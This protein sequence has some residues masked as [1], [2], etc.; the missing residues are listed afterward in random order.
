MAEVSVLLDVLIAGLL[1][2]TI[3]YAVVLNRKLGELR[4]NKAEMEAMVNRL[5]ETTERAEHGLAELKAA[6]HDKGEELS[7]KVSDAKALS[8][9]LGFLVDKG[10]SLADRME[11]QIGAAR[12][13]TADPRGVEPMGMQDTARP[14]N[15]GAKASTSAAPAANGTSRAAA[16][17]GADA[18]ATAGVDTGLRAEPRGAPARGGAQNAKLLKA[19]RGVR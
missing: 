2:A 19:L 18:P 14:A 13:V 4:N 10:T 3:F 7:Q 15:T 1:A 17:Q 6:A 16:N 12:K 9:D 5:V 11:R 8:D